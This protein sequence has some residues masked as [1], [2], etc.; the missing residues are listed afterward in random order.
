VPPFDEHGNLPP[1]VHRCTFEEVALRLGTGSP[2]RQVE[3]KELLR[4]IECA[5][6][7]GAKRPLINGSFVTDEV[8][9]NDVDI[10]VLP[11]GV[12]PTDPPF[13]EEGEKLWPF[14]HIQVAADDQDLEDWINKDFGIDR[15]NRPKG[16]IEVIL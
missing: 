5:R 10:V 8:E 15:N 14:L 4:F 11:G 6:S 9:P 16:V 7:V 12:Y 3:T 1:G 2:E 13:F